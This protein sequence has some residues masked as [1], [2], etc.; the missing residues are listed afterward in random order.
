M[1][2]QDEQTDITAEL[3]AV[4][5]RETGKVPLRVNSQTIIMVHKHNRNKKYADEYLKK[6]EDRKFNW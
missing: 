1:K 5:D 4:R 3:K 6:L 2:R